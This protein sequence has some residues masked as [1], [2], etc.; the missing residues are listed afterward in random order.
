[1]REKYL[2]EMKEVADVS[3]SSD[4]TQWYPLVYEN[5]GVLV[6]CQVTTKIS[7][8]YQNH[9]CVTTPDQIYGCLFETQRY[10]FSRLNVPLA[11]FPVMIFLYYFPFFDFF[12]DS[13]KIGFSLILGKYW[14]IFVL[15]RENWPR[16]TGGIL[17]NIGQ[18]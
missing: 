1:M 16:L 12:P 13:E 15:A 4:M 14:P 7:P 6:A 5:D 9:F 17:A 10:N 2:R 18:N 3:D 8:S 11:K